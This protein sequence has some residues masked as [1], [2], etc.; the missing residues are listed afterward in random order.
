VLR[1][2]SGRPEDRW[3]SRDLAAQVAAAARAA[4]L[5]V[6]ADTT[7]DANA[8]RLRER[9]AELAAQGAD[10]A[11][12]AGE[13]PGAAARALDALHAADPRLALHA[14]GAL[15]RPALADALA[16]ATAA[17]LRLTSAEPD[18]DRGAGARFAAR[19]RRVFRRAPGPGAAAAY[20]AMGTVIAAVRAAGARG[21]DREAVLDELLGLSGMRGP[22]GRF[23]ID[24]QGDT[25]VER[26]AEVRVRDGELVHRPAR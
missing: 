25:T 21:N 9:A 23:A 17:R 5:E 16:P 18:L 19:F 14:S 20:E 2:R 4:G 6:V 24:E 26:I 10:A 8:P 15:A 12:L 11:F 13:D 22:S 1:E 7:V 3:A